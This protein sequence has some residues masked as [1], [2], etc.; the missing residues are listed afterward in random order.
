[1]SSTWQIWLKNQA[2]VRL[3][4]LDYY[5]KFSIGRSVNGLC[6]FALE[7]S[8]L[9]THIASLALDGQL[10][11]YRANLE[12]AVAPYLELEALIRDV[13]EA[14]DQDGRTVYTVAGCGYNELLR[15]RV[16]NAYSGSAGAAKDGPAETVIKEFVEEQCGVTAG[17]RAIFGLSVEGDTMGGGP[18]RLSRA[19]RNVYEVCLEIAAVGGGD[20]AVVGTGPG[21]YEFQWHD[22]QLGTDKSASVVFALEYGN[23]G[24][25]KLAHRRS[26]EITAVLVGGQGDGAARVT[27]WRI[28]YA[29]ESQS[30]INL[31]EMFI[32]QRQ[33]ADP[34]GLITAGDRAL[35]DGRAPYNLSFDILQV[36]SCLYGYHYFLGD[37]VTVRFK[38]YTAVQQVKAVEFVV[39]PDG[40]QLKVTLSEPP[41][42]YGT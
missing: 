16:I 28:D 9:D 38:T 8:G 14:M 10:E 39:D 4:L 5:R 23:M 20:F 2:G 35:A 31:R 26:S 29:R 11:F 6:G 36:P 17:A 18:V 30:P 3:A 1:M 12:M 33:D 25:P 34:N 40:E 19:Y 32:D 13:E 15:R 21:T 42:E 22:G 7:L 41:E 24:S 27:D 37:L